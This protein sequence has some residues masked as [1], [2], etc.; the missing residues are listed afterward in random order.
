MTGSVYNSLLSAPGTAPGRVH[1]VEG[2]DPDREGAQQAGHLHACTG[3]HDLREVC[4][5]LLQTIVVVRTLADAALADHGLQGVARAHVEKIAGQAEILADTIRR[6][7]RPAGA[8]R[9]RRRLFDLRHLISG[10]ADGERVT[11]HD[12]LYII[13]GPAPVFIHANLDDVRRVLANL[14]S[15]ATRAAGPTGSVVIEVTVEA[16]LAEV[17]IDNTAPMCA[18]A[19]ER[20]GLGRNI[21]CQRLSGMAGEPCLRPRQM[22]RRA[23]Y[24]AAAACG[25]DDKGPECG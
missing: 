14:L 21:I 15:N 18:R 10:L 8:D 25:A 19:P 22:K 20:T 11:Y 24:V 6:R 1:T 9:A 23:R 4:H 13:A 12:T 3:Q 2:V 5:D 16:G 7:L 17:A